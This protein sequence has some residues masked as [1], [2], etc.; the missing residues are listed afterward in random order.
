MDAVHE[1]RAASRRVLVVEDERRMRE[2]LERALASMEFRPTLAGT[3]EDGLSKLAEAGAAGFGIVIADLNLPGMS[4]LDFCARVRAASPLTQIV[5]LTGYGDL[6]AARRAIRLDV[7]DFLTKPTSLGDLEAALARAL[8]RR[9]ELTTAA[10]PGHV[11]PDL[12][13]EE[14]PSAAD[15]GTA[16]R[17]PASLRQR[18]REMIY[19]ALA[20]HDGNRAAAAQELGISVRTLYYRLREYDRDGR[21]P[22]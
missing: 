5:I 22:E 1:A 9:H 17:G 13:D 8:R 15:G 3:A 6:G 19:A 4:G 14:D 20:R 18:E 12:S 10:A 21:T 7:V 2:M 16:G 11:P